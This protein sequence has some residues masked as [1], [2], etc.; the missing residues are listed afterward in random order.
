MAVTNGCQAQVA[1]C[2]AGYISRNDPEPQLLHRIRGGISMAE[3][4]TALSQDGLVRD[5]RRAGRESIAVGLGA[6]RAVV[7]G[8]AGVWLS[9]ANALRENFRQVLRGIAIAAASQVDAKQ[10]QALADPATRN[11]EAYETAV[12]PL[13]A[14]RLAVPAVLG[15][16]TVTR[17]GDDVRYVLDAAPGSGL[18]AP[19]WQPHADLKSL[20]KRA[21]DDPRGPGSALAT[22]KPYTDEWG[23]IMT[24][25]APLRAADGTQ[26]GVIGVDVDAG[27]Y[28]GRLGN[29]RRAALWGVAP[30]V[31]MVLCLSVLYYRARFRGLR[32]AS[33]AKAAAQGA[34]QS[35][36]VLAAERRRLHNVIDGTNVSTWEAVVQTGEIRTDP[37]YAQMM[38]R[39][40][41]E[42]TPMT[43]DS[44][45]SLLHPDDRARAKTAIEGCFADPGSV[46]EIDF[47][48][49]HKAGHWVWIRT[50]GTVIERDANQQPVLM[51]GTHI[52]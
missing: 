41:A 6:L 35:A 23:S 32:A 49:L 45:Y 2:D 21:F 33:V 15:I 43:S 13:R 27:R 38:G 46:F 10:H 51:V 47:R 11:P 30:A 20:L 5:R 37:R 18:D 8:I 22:D 24:G 3:A 1:K 31:L 44:W 12:A 25:W 42:L 48:M 50:R 36:R 7:L 40:A 14:M 29:A 52:D 17:D 34:A 39:T 16:Y 28:L 9:A 26:F 19:I 4:A